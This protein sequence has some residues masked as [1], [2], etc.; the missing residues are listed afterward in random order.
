[1]I[2][3]QCHQN[4]GSIA[5]ASP[6]TGGNRNV[7]FQVDFKTLLQAQL[8]LKQIRCPPG[9]VVAVDWNLWMFTRYLNPIAPAKLQQDLIEKI[10]AT[11]QGKQFVVTIR[12]FAA[13]VQEKINF[14][15]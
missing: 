3:V 4:A 15:R 1:M 7:L 5:A 13:H 12:A 8:V 11:H 14:G 6:E 2:G 10:D 9:E